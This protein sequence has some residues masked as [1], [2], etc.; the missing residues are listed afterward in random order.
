MHSSTGSGSI[1]PAFMAAAGLGVCLWFRGTPPLT[2]PPAQVMLGYTP[3][4]QEH[5]GIYTLP[6]VNK[7]RVITNITCLFYS[8]CM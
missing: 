2:H 6:P 5:A 7:M 8:A 1:P 3:S 4:T